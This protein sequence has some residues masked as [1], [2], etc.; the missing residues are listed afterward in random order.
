VSQGIIVRT[1]TPDDELRIT[2]LLAASYPMLMAGSYDATLL[3]AALPNMTRARPELLS[4]GDC[5][6]NR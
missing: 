3:A 5:F 4:A 2:E 1:A 6:I